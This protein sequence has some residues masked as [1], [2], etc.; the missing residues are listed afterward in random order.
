MLRREIFEAGSVNLK[1]RV[2]HKDIELAESSDGPG[3]CL[4]TKGTVRYVARYQQALATFGLYLFLR[5][6]GI[7]VLVEV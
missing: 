1:S 2:V 5:F 6:A 7:F 4:L 3:N